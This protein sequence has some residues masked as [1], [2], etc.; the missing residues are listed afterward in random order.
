[1]NRNNHFMAR[2]FS[3]LLL[4][5]LTGVFSCNKDNDNDDDDLKDGYFEFTIGGTTQR[6]NNCSIVRVLSGGYYRYVVTAQQTGSTAGRNSVGIEINYMAPGNGS[7]IDPGQITSGSEVHIRFYYTDDAG[8]M[9]NSSSTTPTPFLTVV[10]AGSK[11]LEV[12]NFSARITDGTNT[13]TMT[14]S[15]YART[16]Q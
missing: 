3:V 8:R 4:F 15:F 5:S 6:Y 10:D 11:F 7:E 12:S 9:F 16:A 1:M 14:G 13:Q 2:L